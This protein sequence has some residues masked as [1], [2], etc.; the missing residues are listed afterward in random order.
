M[1]L[2]IPQPRILYGILA[3]RHRAAGGRR[4]KQQ[5]VKRIFEKIFLKKKFIL[6]KNILDDWHWEEEKATKGQEEEYSQR[7]S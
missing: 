1:Q 3:G 5:E 2:F 7:K 4:K 6:R